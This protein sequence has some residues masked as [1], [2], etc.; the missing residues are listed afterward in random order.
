MTYL[1][2][3]TDFLL[4]LVIQYKYLFLFPVVVAEG[5]L[6]TMASGFLVSI[7]LMDPLIALPIIIAGDVT[8]DLIYY[9][10]GRFGERLAF[11]RWVIKKFRFESI[12]EKIIRSFESHSGK[13]L[14]FGKLTHALGA[15]F[16]IGA[17]YSRMNIYRFAWYAI[18]GTFIKS[19][20]LLYVGYL[21]GTAYKQYE[22]AFEYW[23]LIITLASI[24][25]ITIFVYFSHYIF[26]HLSGIGLEN[27]RENDK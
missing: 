17:G 9:S 24:L 16:L 19:S 22:Q 21:A 25:V 12:K 5:P 8:G 27:N 11:T 14:L 15:V 26:D 4:S 7:G 20:I 18:L 6:V 13:L 1:L 10:I 23:A 2:S 3:A